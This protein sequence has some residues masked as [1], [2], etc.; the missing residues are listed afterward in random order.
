MLDTAKAELIEDRIAAHRPNLIKYALTLVRNPEEAED[1]TQHVLLRALNKT[2]LF[3]EGTSLSAWL[4]TIMRN[5]HISQRRRS[6]KENTIVV[7]PSDSLWDKISAPDN[8]Y[9]RVLYKHICREIYKLPDN[10]SRLL[11]AVG[12]GTDMEEVIRLEDVPVGTVRSRLWRGRD[13]LRNAMSDG[14]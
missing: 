12:Y 4:F 13:A 1:L 10:Q 6:S 9:D 11:L 7:E 14:E 5:E 3:E 8:Q 2:H